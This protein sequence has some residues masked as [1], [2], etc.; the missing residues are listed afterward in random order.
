MNSIVWVRECCIFAIMLNIRRCFLAIGVIVAAAAGTPKAAGATLNA[1][2][3]LQISFIVVAP[4]C[5]GGSCDVLLLFPNETGAFF[6]TGATASLFD[7]NTLLGTYFNSSCC[8]PSFR[9]SS[10]LFQAGSATVDF[11]AINSGTINGIIDMSIATGSLT[12]PSTPT[13]TLTI[14][15]GTGPGSATGG[16]GVQITSVAIIPEPSTVATLLGGL[17]LLASRRYLVHR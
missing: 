11:T 6:D 9:S 3:I 7:G 14:G 12:W 8:A 10:S 17:L 13:P 1:G 16:T 2:D 5:P 4:V 15:R